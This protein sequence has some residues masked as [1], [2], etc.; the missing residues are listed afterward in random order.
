MRIHNPEHV[1]KFV[2]QFDSIC[3]QRF[4]AGLQD[5]Y[6][7][8][9]HKLEHGGKAVGCVEVVIH[10][11]NKLLF[12]RF[13]LCADFRSVFGLPIP[14]IFQRK[15]KA[16]A[17]GVQT[18][19]RRFALLDNIDAVID[20]ASVMGRNH[21]IANRLIAVF[22][23]HVAHGEKVAERLGHFDVIDVDIAVVHPI[24]G[25]RHA[26]A[27][28]ALRDFVFMVRENQILP[29]AVNVNR[30]TE[31]AAHHCRALNVPAGSAVAPRGRPVRLAG[32][33]AFPKGKVH[34]VFFQLADV[35]PR[36]G[37]QILQG[38][39]RKLAVFREIFGTEIHV[40]IFHRVR[41]PFLDQSFDNLDNFVDIF[42]RFRVNGR[43]AEV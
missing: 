38:L 18:R 29:A 30:I 41:V 37:F 4:G 42:R 8:V 23:R 36:T 31:I 28:L 27:A 2:K 12:A 5:G 16:V 10:R 21:Q 39:V 9:A 19:Q 6:V 33:C 24:I 3:N 35:N 17:A 20:G 25:K 1:R 26:V 32:F 11:F 7:N 43:F 13:H 34:R 14:R 40:A 22:F 15:V